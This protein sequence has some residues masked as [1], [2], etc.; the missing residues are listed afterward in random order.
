MNYLLITNHV[1]ISRRVIF[2]HSHPDGLRLIMYTDKVKIVNPLGTKR[3]QQ[4]LVGF[5]F[6]VENIET[7]YRST[8]KNIHLT[9]LVKNKF[10]QLYGYDTMTICWVMQ[11]A[12]FPHVFLL[13]EFAV[14]A[15]Q[16]KMR[17]MYVRTAMN[18]ISSCVLLRSMHIMW[19]L[20]R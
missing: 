18:H 14:Y 5:Y 8:L 17:Y 19:T 12:D 13:G 9:L 2:F 11:L 15:W 6:V 7:R 16:I 20:F 3:G 4:K 10:L 1:L